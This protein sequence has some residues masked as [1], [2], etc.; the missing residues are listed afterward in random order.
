M[1][2]GLEEALEV[3]RGDP[4]FQQYFKGTRG[5]NSDFEGI[6]VSQC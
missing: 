6:D 4:R 2:R 5:L 3:V 1:P